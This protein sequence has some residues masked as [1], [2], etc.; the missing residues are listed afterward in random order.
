MENNETI[1]VAP[2]G[3]LTILLSGSADSSNKR[4]QLA[5]KTHSTSPNDA[6]KT[7]VVSS[8][9]MRL[10]S[11]VWRTMFDPQGHF[12]ESSS[13]GTVHFAEDNPAA[14]LLVL[15]IAH[16]QFRKVPDVLGFQ[17]MVELAVVCDK[18]DTAGLVR[19]WIKQWEESLQER[20]VLVE[21][22][23]REEYLI[24]AWTF[25]DLPTYEKIADRL[26]CNA[27]CDDRDRFYVDGN[28]L[29]RNM[30][31]GAVGESSAVG[32]LNANSLQ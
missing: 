1:H 10:A 12:M 14:L 2:S 8:A 5:N 31:P 21:E 23:G 3:D 27:T 13:N 25:G 26:I 24:F 9:V 11:P 17:E 29:G 16:L 32:V 30:P 22:P 15:R 7:F 28:P 4:R 18:Y 6:Q 20:S 19:P